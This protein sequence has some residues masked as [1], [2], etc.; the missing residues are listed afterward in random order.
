MLLYMPSKLQVEVPISTKTVVWLSVSRAVVTTFQVAITQ[1]SASAQYN[2]HQLSATCNSFAWQ[3]SLKYTAF[4]QFSLLSK[5]G[6]LSS[7]ESKA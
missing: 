2:D 5:L 7:W 6:G 3:R 1:P 4:S